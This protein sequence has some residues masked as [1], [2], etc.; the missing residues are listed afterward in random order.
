M[1]ILCELREMFHTNITH[2]VAV[3]MWF[4]TVLYNML[5]KQVQYNFNVLKTKIILHIHFVLQALLAAATE[6]GLRV[7]GEK[8]KFEFMFRE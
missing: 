1:K 7:N 6:V 3:I 2:Q 8:P 4:A 5:W